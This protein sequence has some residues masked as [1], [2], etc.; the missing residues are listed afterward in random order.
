MGAYAAEERER[1]PP[2]L[3]PTLPQFRDDAPQGDHLGD[4]SAIFLAWR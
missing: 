4:N 3:L 1:C 2:M